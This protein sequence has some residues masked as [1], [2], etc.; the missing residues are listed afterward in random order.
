MDQFLCRAVQ[1]L[2]GKCSSVHDIDMAE[3][4]QSQFQQCSL[5]VILQKFLDLPVQRRFRM[6]SRG[7][8]HFVG[9]T[10]IVVSDHN[11]KRLSFPVI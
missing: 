11:D 10:V 4:I 7:G 8:I 9:D 3:L 2:I 5:S 6:Q 1:D